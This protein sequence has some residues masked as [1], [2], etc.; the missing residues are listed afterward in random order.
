MIVIEYIFFIKNCILG[1]MQAL[2]QLYDH[3]QLF[4]FFFQRRSMQKIYTFKEVLQAFKLDQNKARKMQYINNIVDIINLI[5]VFVRDV[6]KKKNRC[7]DGQ[8]VCCHLLRQIKQR[9]LEHRL[10]T[11]TITDLGGK[12]KKGKKI[13]IPILDGHS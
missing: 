13:M 12:K 8:W 3:M 9:K 10:K 1:Y 7:K 4:V 2:E 6:E 11:L 5:S